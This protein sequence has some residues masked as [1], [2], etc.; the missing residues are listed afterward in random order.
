MLHDRI[1]QIIVAYETVARNSPSRY[2]V[3][4]CTARPESLV[5]GLEEALKLTLRSRAPERRARLRVIGSGLRSA[6]R[7]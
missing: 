2:R 5:R 6:L 4:Y 3:W 1:L 7:W